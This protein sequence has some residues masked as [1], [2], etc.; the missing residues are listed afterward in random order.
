MTLA[1]LVA[2]AAG[3][4]AYIIYWNGYLRSSPEQW[5]DVAKPPLIHVTSLEGAEGM[6]RDGQPGELLIRRGKGLPVV[7]LQGLLPTR[8]A[9]A[10]CFCSRQ[11][12]PKRIAVARAGVPYA[13]VIVAPKHVQQLS[14]VQIGR[15]WRDGAVCLSDDYCGPA[16]VI[17]VYR[18]HRQAAWRTSR[19]PLDVPLAARRACATWRCSGRCAVRRRR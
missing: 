18:N 9:R 13:E 17:I 5:Q 15:R 19:V 14:V 4:A 10:A 11:A 1:L 16:Q 7:L 12:Q 2:A 3:L 6:Q 8:L